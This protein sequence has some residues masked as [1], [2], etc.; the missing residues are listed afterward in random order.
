M[1]DR[2][3]DQSEN[4]LVAGPFELVSPLEG[5][6]LAGPGVRWR[7]LTPLARVLGSIPSRP[8]GLRRSLL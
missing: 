2:L 1:C 3:W 5:R 7:L 4:D 6:L 8:I